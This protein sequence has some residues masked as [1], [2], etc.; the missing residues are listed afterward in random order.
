[1]NQNENQQNGI[2]LFDGTNYN[3]WSFRLETLLDERNLLQYIE[4]SLVEIVAALPTG[5]T[6]A[7][8]KKCEENEKK[9]KTI[10]VRTIHDCQLETIKGKKSVK[11]MIDA[12]RAIYERK[13]ISS[14]LFLR[15]QLLTLKYNE[16]E[17]MTN[18]FMIFDKSIRSLKSSGAEMGEI[19]IVCLLLLSMPKSFDGLV[20]AIE[21]MEPNRITTEFVKNSL[22]DESNKR[23]HG[24]SSIKL[25]GS[26]AMNTSVIC[27][28]CGKP[29]HYKSQC[30]QRKKKFGNRKKPNSSQWK[31]S[32]KKSETAN[33]AKTEETREELLCA[34]ETNKRENKTDGKFD[35]ATHIKFVL[36][37]GATEHMVNNKEYFDCVSNIDDVHISVAKKNQMIVARQKGDITIQTFFNG[38]TNPKTIKNVLIVKELKCNL[39]SIKSL[40]TRGY[41][42]NF[43]KDVANVSFNG[44]TIFVAHAK[45]KLYEVILYRAE[46]EH[47]NVTTNFTQN[48]WHYRL[49]HLN[50]VDMKKLIYRKMVHGLERVK[51][52]SETDFCES[53]IFGKQTR[54]PFPRKK[55]K[56]SNRILELIHSDL[57]GPMSQPA[58]DGSNYFVTFMDD[59]SR[60]SK[61]YCIKY[62]SEAIDKFREYVAMAETHYGVK[63]AKLRV[64]NGGEYI[65]LE[66]KDFCKK[67]GIQ[68]QYITPYNPEMNSTSERLN[69]TLI[70]KARTMLLASGLNRIFW[71]EAVMA[72][73]YIKNRCPTEAV[74]D[75]FRKNTPA[76]IWNKIKP[77]LFNLRVFGCVCYNH[78]PIEKKK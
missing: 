8:K 15:K 77:N 53:C 74:G 29:G 31:N 5:A 17:E 19:E 40:T 44:K 11:E 36:D 51:L 20:T 59:Y 24:S 68:V 23:N 76:E 78:I 60:A 72:S 4:Q 50:V 18:H 39:M 49:G 27:Y 66:F 9:C 35:D 6:E 2:P 22:L 69:R 37:S 46:R 14:Q 47:A 61:I 45:G 48:L 30:L 16:S 58:W 62:K 28:S 3:N 75:Q 38:D 1:M 7:D 65:S 21:T 26:S 13:S 42:V 71:N 10:I 32:N 63:I 55:E 67:R 73:N 64:D 12:L 57:C 52:A 54:M 41:K 56:R 25:A 34:V 33:N 70:E 43:E